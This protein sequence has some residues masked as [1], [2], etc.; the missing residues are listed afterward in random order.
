MRRVT[1]CYEQ[2]VYGSFPF[3]DRGY[4]ILA[5]SPG[6]RPEWLTGLR[7]AAQ[8]HGERPTDATESSAVFAL[9]L[10]RGPWMIV[11][12][13]PQGE[14]DRGRPGAL[15]FHA[16]F[17]GDRQYRRAG[18]SPFAFAGALRHTWTA[19]TTGLP[20]GTWTADVVRP[21]PFPSVWWALG[22]LALLAAAGISRH[23]GKE[24]AAIP[25]T[26]LAVSP[27]PERS[28]YR[29]EPLERGQN[30]QVAEA[31]TEVAERF[32][33]SV[34]ESKGTDDDD[35]LMTTLSDHLCY[36]GPLLSLEDLARLR[37]DVDPDGA[38]D[39]AL[40]LAWHAHV[41]RFLGDRALPEGFAQGPLRWQL[42]TLAWRFHVD[43]DVASPRRSITEVPHALAEALAVDFPL[44]NLAQ[45]Q[46]YPAL[47]SYLAF[48][49]R[50]PRR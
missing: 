33:V 19:E 25:P 4:A 17:V 42:A 48:L 8:R 10:P 18:A 13:S 32:G 36:R 5:Q 46:R 6:C 49:R 28:L 40:A 15:A 20:T 2:A 30:R 9:R 22:A 29:D 27:A 41:C 31:L 11:G 43:A 44:R 37:T 1:I 39:R 7:A 45:A 3:W 16:L 14:D 26:K 23:L 35:V 12:V 34:D 21:A 38:R 24:P 47:G 50:L